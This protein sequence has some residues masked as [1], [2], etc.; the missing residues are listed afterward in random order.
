MSCSPGRLYST[1]FSR[2]TILAVGPTPHR[3]SGTN[4][5]HDK[6]L[7]S[8]AARHLAVFSKAPFFDFNPERDLMLASDASLKVLRSSL[9]PVGIGLHGPAP[10]YQ[11]SHTTSSVVTLCTH[12]AKASQQGCSCMARKNRTWKKSSPRVSK[13][14][15]CGT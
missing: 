11:G 10:I 2:H 3:L 14:F 5:K 1:P 13:R 12:F 4:N 8:M 15:S 6:D 9:I 7:A